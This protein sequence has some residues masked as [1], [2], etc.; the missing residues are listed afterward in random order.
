MISHD[1]GLAAK[2]YASK[3]DL[4]AM[5]AR[6]PDLGESLNTAAHELARDISLEKIDAFLAKVK[7]AETSLMHLRRSLAQQERI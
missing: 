2:L 3:P 1:T 6:L 5:R 7:G 4:D